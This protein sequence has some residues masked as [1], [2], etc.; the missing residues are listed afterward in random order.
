MSNFIQIHSWSGTDPKG[1]S[2]R[3]AKMF[4]L[5]PKEAASI[6]KGLQKGNSWQF[7]KP[8]PLAQSQKA[9]D[10]LNAMGFSAELTSGEPSFASF[11]DELLEEDRPQRK[12][13]FGFK[14]GGKEKAPKEKKGGLFGFGKKKSGQA[15]VPPPPKP[16]KPPKPKKPKRPKGKSS[17]GSIFAVLLILILGAGAV[18]PFWF[19][20]EAEKLVQKQV[21]HW[22]K[23]GVLIQIVDYQRGWLDTNAKFSV[24]SL[25]LPLSVQVDS[26]I[27]HGPIPFKDLFDQLMQGNFSFEGFQIMQARADSSLKAQVKMP[28][29]KPAPK[30][31]EM[32]VT[33]LIPFKGDVK[34]EITVAPFYSPKKDAVRVNWQGMSGTITSALDW[35]NIHGNLTSKPLAIESKEGKLTLANS[36]FTG[37]VQEGPL[38]MYIGSSNIEVGSVKLDSAM[39]MGTVN[40]F[41]VYQSANANGNLY[42]FIMNLS[43][44]RAQLDKTRFGPVTFKTKV[45]NIDGLTLKKLQ[46]LNT[47]NQANLASGKPD[48]Q[49]TMKNQQEMMKLM[50]DLTTKVPEFEISQFNIGTEHGEFSS[51]ARVSIDG[52]DG[53]LAQNPLMALTKIEAEA[54]VKIPESLMDHLL[55]NSRSLPGKSMSPRK[56]RKELKT[57]LKKGYLIK[58]DGSY[59]AE[60]TFLEGQLEVNGKPIK[61]MPLKIN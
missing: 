15:D 45:K 46:D 44:Q 2:Q 49:Q 30:L 27:I 39:G 20:M 35:Q 17:A 42:N 6:V 58:Q 38:G 60:L 61:G 43:L 22:S 7:D 4:K 51:F 56:A 28:G 11:D 40:N 19:G 32:L 57:L 31:P 53:S 12:S 8:I 26:H 33:T 23:K 54:G 50:A 48:M 9:M 34:E 52:S 5:S 41:K 24:R 55:K 36:R 13:L 47:Q 3:L 25:K 21:D 14:R 1:V 59:V 10:Y 29:K 37:D 16:G 18:A